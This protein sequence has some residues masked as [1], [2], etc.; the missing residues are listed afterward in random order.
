LVVFVHGGPTSAAARG[1]LVHIRFWTSRGFAV[2]DVDYRGSTG[3]GRAYRELLRGRWCESDVDDALA[4]AQFL[5]RRGDVDEDRLL[6][7]G[8]SAGGTTTLLALASGDT[9]AAGTNYFGV[10]DLEALMSDD[11]KFESNYTQQLIGPW[12]DAADRYAERSPINRVGEITAP[13]LVLQG[14]DDHVVPPSHSERV[15]EAL[16]AKGITVG[17]LVFAGEGHG[18]RRA[19]S[20]IR[21]LEAELWF[22]GHVLGFSP[23]DHLEPVPMSPA[24]ANVDPESG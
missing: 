21:A 18:F 16:Q 9:F 13:L 5:A 20:R 22:Y 24:Q 12:P 15:V 23:A 14:S 8:G 17:Y 11:H 10:T 19:D 3:Y 1:Y 4:A 2:V 6:I 7:R